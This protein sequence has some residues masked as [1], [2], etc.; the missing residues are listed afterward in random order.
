MAEESAS[1]RGREGA[2]GCGQPSAGR[3]GERITGPRI[4]TIARAYFDAIDA[5]DV[6]ERGRRCGPTAGVS[7]CAG[8]P[9]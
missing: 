3:Q 2:R 5:R 6:D 4:D 7:T 1:T 9:T 8:L